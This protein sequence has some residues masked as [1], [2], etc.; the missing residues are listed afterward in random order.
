MSGLPFRDTPLCRVLEDLGKQ[1]CD[2]R[3]HVV[4]AGSGLVDDVL[5]LPGMAS[6]GH[7]GA[8]LYYGAAKIEAWLVSLIQL[9]VP[10]GEKMYAAADHAAIGRSTGAIRSLRYALAA[11]NADIAFVQALAFVLTSVSYMPLQ[12]ARLRVWQFLVE[13]VKP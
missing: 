8:G 9:F 12:D 3:R 5:E 10:R 2:P 7:R 13:A 11:A 6:F 1:S 4:V